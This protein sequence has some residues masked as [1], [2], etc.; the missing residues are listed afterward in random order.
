MDESRRKEA[1]M[2]ARRPQTELLL[3]AGRLLLEYN[4]STGEIVRVLTSTAKAFTTEPLH[5]VVSYGSVAVSFAGE[6]PVLE[7]VNE[8]HYN[9]AV[10]AQVHAILVRVRNGD[11]DLPSALNL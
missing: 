4:E 1:T 6:S 9:A 2:S 3:E 8:L 10:Q 7:T 11:L 5:V